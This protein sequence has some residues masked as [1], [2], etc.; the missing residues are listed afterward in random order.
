MQK[1]GNVLHY[2]VL[3]RWY[4][5]RAHLENCNRDINTAA[6]KSTFEK[7]WLAAGIFILHSPSMYW[8]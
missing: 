2:V 5:K 1:L 8:Q 3:C 4:M 6:Y 7:N